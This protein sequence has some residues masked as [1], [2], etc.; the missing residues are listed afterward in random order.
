M[1]NLNSWSCCG[2]HLHVSK[3][4]INDSTKWVKLLIISTFVIMTYLA[5]AAADA[6]SWINRVVSLISGSAPLICL[7]DRVTSHS[8]WVYL[9]GYQRGKTRCVH[10]KRWWLSNLN[11]SLMLS[12]YSDK[13]D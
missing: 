9:S 4:F 13:I 1:F 2:L 6:Q 3:S 12:K 7:I 10:C 5:S 8:A 11:R